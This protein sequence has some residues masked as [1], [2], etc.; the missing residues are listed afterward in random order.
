[1]P[2]IDA[3]SNF[4]I[5]RTFDPQT[6]E[7]KKD[8]AVYYDS[9]DLTTHGLIVGMTGS[10][11]T[12]MALG[13]LE[14]AIL[15]GIPMIMV[16]PKGDL[17]NLLL[18]F[19]DFTPS[20]FEPWV[21]EDEARREN[22]DVPTLAAKKA[23][24]WQ[25]GLA[26]W[27]ITPERMH[28]LKA[29]AD[30][31]IYTPGSESGIPV[32]ILA[33]LR[34]PK[35]GFDA[36]AEANREQIS[37]VVTAILSLAGISAAPMQDPRHVLLANIFEHNWRNGQ[38]LTLETLITQIQK[39]PFEK[40]GVLSVEDFYPSKDRFSLVM[41][42]NAVIAAPSFQSWLTGAPMDIQ[43]LLYTP[44]GKPRVA[45][46][47]IAHLNDTE[48][49][50]VMTLILETLLSWV[51]QQ[52]GTSSLRAILYIDEIFGFF[53][54]VANPP[55][56]EPLLRLL[57][58]ARAFGVGVLLAT[59]N[60]IDL[61]YKGLANI[62]S[63]FI[64]RLQ[65]D[66]DRNRIMSGLQEAAQGADMD[67]A[68]VKEM[69]ANLKSRVFLLRNI[70]NK[71]VPVLFSAR[72]AMSYLAGPFTRQQINILMK[73]RKAVMGNVVGMPQEASA[74]SLTPTPSPVTPA[75]FTTQPPVVKDVRQYYLPLRASAQEAISTW[76]A[77]RGDRADGIDEAKVAF[78][79]VLLAQASVMFDDTKPKVRAE[80]HY[81]FRVPDV[82]DSGYVRWAEYSSEPVDKTRLDTEAR[83]EAL[84]GEVPSALTDSK[85]LRALEDDLID[86]IY[87][88]YTLTIP[89]SRVLNVYGEADETTDAF[90]ARIRQQAREAQD[91]AVDEL[92]EKYDDRLAKLDERI[93]KKERE[94]QQD[95]ARVQ[96]QSVND[97]GNIVGGVL[98]ML[99]GGRRTSGLTR[100]G[101]AAARTV[102]QTPAEAEVGE[103]KAELQEL[104]AQRDALVAEMEQALA[105][106]RVKFDEQ[107]AQTEEYAIAPKKKDIEIELFTLAWQPHYLFTSGGAQKL[108]AAD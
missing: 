17:G 55:S 42:L 24:L 32:S 45:I 5:G 29:A 103:T 27:D 46:I 23:E 12:G 41:A 14:E 48:R 68:Q 67:L 91:A 20:D 77:A 58:Q 40:L 105:D 100:I 39:P 2:F 50:F 33:S 25:K 8:E 28:K 56:K 84:F 76:E 66:G 78:V 82:A 102:G 15:D 98:S 6:G 22:T 75:G 64:G 47:Y 69:I 53:P 7:V 4:Y 60:P 101:K 44:Q 61:D 96:Q 36:N 83:G 1:M 85:R 63:W 94:L 35:G 93:T 74:A 97:I 90:A 107:V 57:K 99:G 18:N 89:Y 21:Q 26:D 10:G 104:T 52:A 88:D 106:V 73:E 92:T 72:W 19:P 108:A 34:A 71:G 16:D 43:S 37:S 79:P 9:R 87:K 80:K 81:A 3:P 49:M 11:K 54:P 38:D 59:Q 30:F 13:M 86:T 65:S 95:E 70:H 51:R 62:G 31:T